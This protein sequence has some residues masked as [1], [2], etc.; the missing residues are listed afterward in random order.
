MNAAGRDMIYLGDYTALT[1]TIY[2]HKMYVDT[3]DVS[4]APH[5]LL[6]GYWEQWI[7]NIFRELVKPGMTVV[8]VGANFGY[9]SVLAASLVRPD[10]YTHSRPTRPSIGCLPEQWTSTASCPLVHW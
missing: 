1:R 4:L 2:G 5:L 7:T 9:Y 3:R 6:D 10:T 8:D